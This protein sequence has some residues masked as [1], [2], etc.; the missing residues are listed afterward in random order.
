MISKP[1]CCVNDLR[2]SLLTEPLHHW[3]PVCACNKIQHD[4]T[5]TN[6]KGPTTAGLWPCFKLLL[7]DAITP[8]AGNWCWL[9]VSP[10][11]V[12]SVYPLGTIFTNTPWPCLP[13]SHQY[14]TTQK[15]K[16][17]TLKDI[18]DDDNCQRTLSGNMGD[19]NRKWDAQWCVERCVC[20]PLC[21]CIDVA[22]INYKRRWRKALKVYHL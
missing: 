5:C 17:A 1:H 3:R 10:S 14:P 7:C 18:R 4:C 9:F 6:I 12:L 19:R 16:C 22:T 2:H 11:F 13:F 8:L 15:N 21:M 20:V